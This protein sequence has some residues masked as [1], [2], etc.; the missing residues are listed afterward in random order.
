MGS[1]QNG[2]HGNF[3]RPVLVLKKFNYRM[4]L[5]VPIST[6]VGRSP[7]HY[8]FLINNKGYWANMSQI[9][10]FSSKRL[11]R[12]FHKMASYDFLKIQNLL[13]ELT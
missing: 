10:T 8:K 9:R 7:Y 5:G 6:K 1:E 4:L 12:R 11:L 3:E 13:R 2:K